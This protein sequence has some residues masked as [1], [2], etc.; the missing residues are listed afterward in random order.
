MVVKDPGRKGW[1]GF[2]GLTRQGLEGF[3]SKKP[4]CV[5]LEPD[6]LGWVRIL[7]LLLV[8]GD[9]RCASVPSSVKCKLSLSVS[10]L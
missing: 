2:G 4:L 3:S 7:L 8:T 6:C 10:E 5:S 1:E 9:F